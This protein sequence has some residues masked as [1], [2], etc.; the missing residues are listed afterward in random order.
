MNLREEKKIGIIEK[1]NNKRLISKL[2]GLNNKNIYYKSKK[3]LKDLKI[4]NEIEKTFEK[5][6]AYGY[7]RLSIE[8]QINKKKIRR[9]MN[10]FGLKPPRLWYQK[11]YTTK[12]NKDYKDK[13]DN[14]IRNIAFPKPNEIWSSDL[15]YI[16]HKGRFFYLSAIQ[17][18]ATKE[19]ISFNL[20][21]K[22]NSDLILK[23]IK[24]GVLKYQKFPRIFHSDRGKEFLN[25]SCINYFKENKVQISASDPG[26][27][28]Q[29][30]HSES[31]FSRFKA[32][33]GDL[34]RFEDL[35]ELTEYIYQYINYYNN[36]RIITR[37]KMSP[38]KF[39]RSQRICS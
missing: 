39:K 19:I 28:W 16:K 13:F 37:L 20:R 22:H 21:D 5:H 10:K 33:T 35:G 11:R 18:I 34:N 2:M 32:E 14:L 38:M 26:S 25:E 23:T 31:F 7:R 17:D 8:L 1:S 29:N 36:E 27:P 6:P 15:T 3:E 12:Q 9:I 30:G 4:K 24:E